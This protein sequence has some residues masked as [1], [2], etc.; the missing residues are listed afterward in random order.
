M[1]AI[2]GPQNAAVVVQGASAAWRRIEAPEDQR[3]AH[4]YQR[5]HEEQVDLRRESGLRDRGGDFVHWD[6]LLF[7]R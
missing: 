7:R 6:A 1:I 5:H 4:D 3:H 2:V